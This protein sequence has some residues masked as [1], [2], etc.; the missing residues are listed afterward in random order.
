MTFIVSLVALL[1]ERF[2]DWSHLRNWSWFGNYTRNILKRVS[3]VTSYGALAVVVL[4]VLVG[5]ALVQFILQGW[6]YGLLSLI[7]QVLV[8]LYCL[9]PA[10]LWADAFATITSL[11]QG[12]VSFASDKLK[13]SF[14]MSASG[15][16]AKL[17]HLLMDGIF[18]HAYRRV[19]AVVFWYAVLGPVGAV[20]YRLVVLCAEDSALAQSARTVEDVLNWVPARLITLLFALGG[21]FSH[22]INCWRKKTNFTL[23]GSDQFV[24]DC[25]AAALGQEDLERFPVDGSVERNAVALLD[26]SFVIG[27]VLI[28]LESLLI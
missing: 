6:L 7:F 11:V 10:N 28:L 9:G 3:G 16:T 4:P 21:N 18:I 15:E 25:G 14:G 5:V 2:F 12:D 23:A 8:L 1:I 19:F 24:V 20:L 22:V 27:L 26:R 17:H 13:S